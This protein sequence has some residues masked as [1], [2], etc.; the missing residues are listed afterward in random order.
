MG[1]KKSI[2]SGPYDLGMGGGSGGGGG[3]ITTVTV[4]PHE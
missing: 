2:I 1:T 4:K 3:G